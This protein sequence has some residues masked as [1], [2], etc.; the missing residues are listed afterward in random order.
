MKKVDDRTEYIN[1]HFVPKFLLKHFTRVNELEVINV[2]DLLRNKTYPKNISDVCYEKYLN[3][4]DY[5]KYIRSEYECKHDRTIR[6]IKEFIYQG[7]LYQPIPSG[8][9]NEITDM[10]A[11]IH[12]HNLFWRKTMADA[13]SKSIMERH[14]MESYTIDYHSQDIIPKQLL[15][16]WKKEL[17]RWRIIIMGNREVTL[18][19]IIPDV[20]VV[21]FSLSPD[22][23]TPNNLTTY[24]NGYLGYDENKKIKNFSIY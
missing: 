11:F 10:V 7:E 1:N 2:T 3:T 17:Y 24:F 20:P 23:Q 19:Y 22:L 8:L 12:S 16:F 15:D 6:K 18:N 4:V 13:V 9:S 21:F 14:D 5:E